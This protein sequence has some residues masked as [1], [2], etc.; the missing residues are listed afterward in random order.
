[1]DHTIYYH[2]H[3][4]PPPLHS[5]P[6]QSSPWPVTQFFNVNFIIS[7]Y[8]CM[9]FLPSHVC[10]IFIHIILLDSFALLLCCEQ[11][12]LWSSSLYIPLHVLF[13]IRLCTNGQNIF[14]SFSSKGNS[15][16]PILYLVV[17]MKLF[18]CDD[19]QGTW[20]NELNLHI[21]ADTWKS[22]KTVVLLDK[23]V[24]S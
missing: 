4:S 12:K 22:L 10:C 11:Y 5:E 14:L 1:M 3:N 20:E 9:N 13:L 6:V 23:K 24:V 15:I 21:S 2:D 18:A 8:L 16:F 19:K 17:F 7:L